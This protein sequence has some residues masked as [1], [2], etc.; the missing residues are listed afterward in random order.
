[1]RTLSVTTTSRRYALLL[2]A[3]AIT[4]GAG[5]ALQTHGAAA[6]GA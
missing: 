2:D 6:R 1:M 3:V 5:E 4:K